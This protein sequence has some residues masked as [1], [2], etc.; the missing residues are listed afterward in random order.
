MK[1]LKYSSLYA[2][3]WAMIAGVMSFPASADDLAA[4]GQAELQKAVESLRPHPTLE[5]TPVEFSVAGIHYRIPKNYLLTMQ[6]W[7]GGPQDIVTVRVNIPDMKPLTEET[8][9]CFFDKSF[10]RTPGCEPF[11]F[12][13]RG[14]GLPADATFSNQKRL[15]H[16]QMPI[17]GP[18][19]FEV[20][21]FGSEG[22]RNE[23]YRK[24]IGGRTTLYSCYIFD[25]HGKRDGLCHPDSDRVASGAEI[26]FFFN[27]RE[28]ADI[29]KIDANLRSLVDRFTVQTK[30]VK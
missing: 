1:A 4:R 26:H 25:N 15:F 13:I 23:I 16:N 28:L 14:I 11:E 19:G 29:T 2:L 9:A 22:A 7:N 24:V 18:F 17:F 27:L 5:T 12:T 21:E 20:Y 6:N 8:R 30:D 3:L 10:N